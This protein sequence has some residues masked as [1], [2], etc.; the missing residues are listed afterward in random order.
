[1]L[2]Q[3]PTEVLDDLK[4]FGTKFNMSIDVAGIMDSYYGIQDGNGVY[5]E[6]HN[7]ELAPP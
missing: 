7:T 1:M 2:R 3:L 6:F 4:D 5:Y